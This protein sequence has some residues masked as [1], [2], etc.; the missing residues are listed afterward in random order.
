MWGMARREK[1]GEKKGEEL[2]WCFS[3]AKLLASKRKKRAGRMHLPKKQ[4][5]G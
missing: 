1:R 5:T 3:G 4:K 2:R